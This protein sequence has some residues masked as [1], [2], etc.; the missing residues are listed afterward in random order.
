MY[1]DESGFESSTTR[2]YGYA[3]RGQ[4]IYGE[5][6]GQTRP[7]T[8]LLAALVNKTL[9]KPM[10][11]DGTCTTKI[12]NTWLK[13]W[14]C[15]ILNEGHVVIMDNAMIHKSQK[16][17][18]LIEKTGA[19]LLFLPP[20]SPD[21][22]PIEQTFGTIKKIRQYNENKSIDDTIKSCNYLCR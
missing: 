1:L 4:K 11:F 18:K 12:F 15:P 3:L 14:L 6:S 19:K 10:L 2:Q 20:Y 17:R 13:N 16:T 9:I 21:L 7:R 22:N 5:R 8:S